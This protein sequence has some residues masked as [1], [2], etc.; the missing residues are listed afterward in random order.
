[1]PINAGPEYFKAEEAYRNAKK[2]EEKIEALEEMIRKLPKHKGTENVLA[3]LKRRLAKLKKETS[4][5]AKSSSKS[6]IRKEGSAQV[7][8]V[9]VTNSG[10]SSLLR[11]LT[12]ADVKVGDYE[13]TTKSPVVGMMDYYG[14]KI[15]LV[16][17]PS[18]FSKSSIGIVNNC[19]LI[20]ILIDGTDDLE[21]Q[22]NSL[23][24]TVGKRRIGLKKTLTVVNK[25]DLQSH[26]KALCISAKTGEGMDE[27][28]DEVWSRL[29]LIR[30]YTKSPG[31]PRSK[32]PI[33]LP[34]G[35]TVQDATKEI[36]KTI[37]KNF[38]FARIFNKSKHSGKK[39]GLGYEL[40]DLDVV[41]I[42]FQ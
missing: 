40:S 37:L 28:K 39:V 18:T 26:G 2:R 11:A 34:I 9:G 14:V 16:E 27:L 38:K 42:H 12:N 8:V 4:G 10:K 24:N 19:D 13:Y 15:Q 7:C 36:H 25:C 33:T 30:V 29:G 17:I 35:S 6:A 21:E 41:E 31:D 3:Q 22:L 5:K 23:R 32:V 1:M 20:L